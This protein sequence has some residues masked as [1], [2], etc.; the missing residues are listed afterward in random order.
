M[1]VAGSKLRVHVTRVTLNTRF[2]DTR[3]DY[4]MPREAVGWGHVSRHDS[5]GPDAL[6]P[7]YSSCTRRFCFDPRA[8]RTRYVQG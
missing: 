2:V 1:G 6:M 8:C 5:T 3:G 7:V 4:G